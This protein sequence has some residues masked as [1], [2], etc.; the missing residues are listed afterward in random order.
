MT[1][2]FA[3]RYQDHLKAVA[4]ANLRNKPILFDALGKLCTSSSV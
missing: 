1:D 3:K 2:D 4:K